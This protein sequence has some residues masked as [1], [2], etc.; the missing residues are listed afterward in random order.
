[1]NT[2]AFI[3]GIE[4]YGE[5]DYTVQGPCANAIAV[6]RWLLE[7]GTPGKNIHI[8]LDP[9]DPAPNI[10][11]LRKAEVHHHGSAT[12]YQIDD[13]WKKELAKDCPPGSRLFVFWSGHGGTGPERRRLLLCHDYEQITNDRFF[14]IRV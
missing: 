13:F 12:K 11:D 10:E 3:V 5:K 6:A 9:G 14:D 2:Y 7:I 8:F 4:T 1:M